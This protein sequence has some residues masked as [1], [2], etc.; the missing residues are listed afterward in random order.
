MSYLQSDDESVLA[1]EKDVHVGD[2]V[3]VGDQKESEHE[4]WGVLLLKKQ[5]K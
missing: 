1:G 2:E 5:R 3:V 4:K